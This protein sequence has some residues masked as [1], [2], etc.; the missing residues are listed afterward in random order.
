MHERVDLLRR[1]PACVQGKKPLQLQS[2]LQ[3]GV[4]GECPPTINPLRQKTMLYYTLRD[5]DA[6]ARM[7]SHQGGT[8]QTSSLYDGY[9]AVVLTGGF[10]PKY[11][12]FSKKVRFSSVLV[13]CNEDG[14][15]A[16]DFAQVL[17]LGSNLNKVIY[18]TDLLSVAN[19]K[20]YIKKWNFNKSF[21]TGVPVFRFGMIVKISSVLKSGFVKPYGFDVAKEL[22]KDDNGNYIIREDLKALH[23]VFTI[24]NTNKVANWATEGEGKK[25]DERGYFDTYTNKRVEKHLKA[26]FDTQVEFAESSKQSNIPK[27]SN[28]FG[29]VFFARSAP[30]WRRKVYTAVTAEQFYLAGSSNKISV[31]FFSLLKAYRN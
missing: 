15:I 23:S 6:N 11:T 1:P 20:L 10:R 8:A 18:T 2:L 17:E 26:F 21:G 4:E 29:Y 28:L 5:D 12:D 19:E 13:A 30:R 16:D 27:Q 9:F 22:K 3:Q 31:C 14:E 7:S 24:E 25:K